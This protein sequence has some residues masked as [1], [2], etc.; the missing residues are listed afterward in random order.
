MKK[1]K[2]KQPPFKIGLMG[3]STSK[4]TGVKDSQMKAVMVAQGRS[5]PVEKVQAMAKCKGKK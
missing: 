5:R 1:S 4:P 2:G 3:E